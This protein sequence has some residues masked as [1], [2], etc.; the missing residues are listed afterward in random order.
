[1]ELEALKGSYILFPVILGITS[2]D[3]AR[4]PGRGKQLATA[5]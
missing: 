1:M 4:E 3:H 5:L 2:P